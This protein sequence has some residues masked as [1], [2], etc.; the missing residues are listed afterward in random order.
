MPDLRPSVAKLHVIYAYAKDNRSIW[1]GMPVYNCITFAWLSNFQILPLQM[2]LGK[3]PAC[4]S[5]FL[6]TSFHQLGVWHWW[7]HPIIQR[8]A[9]NRSQG[10]SWHLPLAE[11]LHGR[12]SHL[13]VLAFKTPGLKG[14]APVRNDNTVL[15]NCC[16]ANKALESG[17]E[18]DY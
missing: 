13:F 16:H 14:S 2:L 11:N 8:D 10:I 5:A 15:S 18:S 6:H 4:H 1:A 3:S 9:R 17:K 12:K 7:C